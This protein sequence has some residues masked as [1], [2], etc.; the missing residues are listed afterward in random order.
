MEKIPQLEDKEIRKYFKDAQKS[1]RKRVPKIL[2]Q[3]GA[4]LNKVFNFVLSDSYMHPHLHP[5]DEKIEKM[6]IIYGSLAVIY[7]DDEGSIKDHFIL[8]ENEETTIEVPANTWHTY[9]MLNDEVIIY[10]TMEG[11]YHPDT[12]KKMAPWAP[13]EN[14]DQ[15]NTYLDFLKTKVL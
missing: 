3:K 7:F 8:K 12:W 14:S 4:Y 5:S 1:E 10:E 2:H 9:V 11:I 13:S 15:A 6:H